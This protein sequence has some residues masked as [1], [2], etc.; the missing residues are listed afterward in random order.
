MSG[1]VLGRHL[2]LETIQVE[3]HT[4][5]DEQGKPAYAAAVD[6]DVRIVRQHKM[7]VAADGSQVRTVLT[8][9]IPSEATTF[10]GEQDRIQWDSEAF[11]VVAMKDVKDRNAQRVHRRVRCRQE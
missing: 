1:V 5:V 11:I 8:I 6:V 9:W 7:T 3:V 4:G 10:A 2:K